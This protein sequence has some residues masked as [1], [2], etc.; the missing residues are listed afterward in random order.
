MT[1]KFL[2]AANVLPSDHADAILIG[3]AWIPAFG[4]PA[5]VLVRAD[6]I[7][8]LS[9]IAATASELYARGDAVVAIRA[10]RSPPTLATFDAALANSDP[11]GRDAAAPWL[12]APCD[13]QPIKASGV[14]FVASMLERVIE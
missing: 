8:D 12:L 7:R 6:G 10:A 11:V 1:G 5:P 9:S 4:G 3:R 13:W 2:D 14:T